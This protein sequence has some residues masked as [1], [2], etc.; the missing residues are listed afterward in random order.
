[1][2]TYIHINIYIWRRTE[3]WRC[4]G[5]L[6]VFYTVAITLDI[7]NI[8]PVTHCLNLTLTPKQEIFNYYYSPNFDRGRT[9]LA[10]VLLIGEWGGGLSRETILENNVHNGG[11]WAVRSQFGERK[12][13]RDVG[14][15][16]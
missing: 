13:K 7:S 11:S 14:S 1:M 3:I 8:L 2:H 16:V 9:F 15:P 12:T 10:F 5:T 4:I 6:S